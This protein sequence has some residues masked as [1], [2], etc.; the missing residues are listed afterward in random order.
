MSSL[1]SPPLNLFFPFFSNLSF[2]LLDAFGVS[3]LLEAAWYTLLLSPI[4][5]VLLLLTAASRPAFISF[6]S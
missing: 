1:S 3:L 5:S 2:R 6:Y 4:E